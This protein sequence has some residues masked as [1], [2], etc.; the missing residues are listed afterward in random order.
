ML[1]IHSAL[2]TGGIETFFVRLAEAR[3][4]RRENTKVLLLRDKEASNPDLL[5][6]ISAVADVVF[7]QDVLVPGFSLARLHP[8]L[9]PVSR[10]DAGRV[11]ALLEGITSIHVTD[12]RGSYL[13]DMLL[14]AGRGKRVPVSVGVYHSREFTWSYPFIPFFERVNRQVFKERAGEGNA[15]F[16]ND[17]LPQVY[18]SHG[19][20][21]Q[22]C[23]VFPLGVVESK[24]NAVSTRGTPRKPPLK[25]VSVG[26]LQPFKSYH[27]WMP[28]LVRD[29]VNQGVAV[30]YD[31][32]GKG[33]LESEIAAEVD[34]LGVGGHINL[35]GELDYSR[36]SEVVSAYDLFVG[37]GTAIV[38][39]ASLGVP[40]VV[41]IE[42]E[43]RPLTYGFFSDIQ[44]FTY[45]EDGV[46]EK[47]PV[48]SCLRQYLGLADGQLEDLRRAHTKK[49]EIF[50]IEACAE[51]FSQ[52]GRPSTAATSTFLGALSR[53]RYVVSFFAFC[54]MLKFLGTSHGRVRY[55]E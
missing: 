10:M 51:N 54:V 8:Y 55:G 15:I 24:H 31:I 47:V 34:R 14:D 49:A 17:K 9:F 5:R 22:D 6:R 4:R 53:W 50:S 38:E 40:S 33:P 18:A 23:P 7:L 1:L 45:N 29:L 35:K 44:G 25:I 43:R 46:A 12:G 13:A 52:I 30:Q 16:F 28:A 37:S 26:R 42:S 27:Y 20:P 11:E 21:V 41:A 3:Y 32:Y 19:Y 36:F 48:L 39:A 2:P